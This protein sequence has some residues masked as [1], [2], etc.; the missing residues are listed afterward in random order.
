MNFTKEKYVG[1]GIGPNGIPKQWEYNYN[2]TTFEDKWNDILGVLYNYKPIAL[3]YMP[4]NKELHQ[5][6][7]SELNYLQTKSGRF[8]FW[9]N[10]DFIDNVLTLYCYEYLEN[11][12]QQSYLDTDSRCFMYGKMLGYNDSDIKGYFLRN[13]YLNKKWNRFIYM[14]YNRCKEFMENKKFSQ[15]S[16]DKMYEKIERDGLDSIEKIKQTELF[17]TLKKLQ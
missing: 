12:K 3:E 15:R 9:K 16:F 13:N 1:A 6:I 7:I 17:K 14:N 10:N 8:I 5:R 11:L 2:L 4:K